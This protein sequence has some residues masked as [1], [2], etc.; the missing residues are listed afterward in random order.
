MNL[1]QRNNSELNTKMAI[2]SNE[3]RIICWLTFDDGRTWHQPEKSNHWLIES[4]LYKVDRSSNRPT[5]P[6][7]DCSIHRPT[8][9]YTDRPTKQ[10][11][12]ST[13]EV[14]LHQSTDKTAPNR[15][16]KSD[17]TDRRS[18]NT[19]ACNR[20]PHT[21][22]RHLPPSRMHLSLPASSCSTPL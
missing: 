17:C 22:V 2:Y 14:G 15:H 10:P 21:S 12:K 7:K 20:T 13:L 6:P 9:R 11:T 5:D 8:D 19:N 4:Q 18:T 3:M 1:F 16:W